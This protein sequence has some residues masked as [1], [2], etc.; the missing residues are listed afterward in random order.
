M[1]LFLY[2][3]A[4]LLNIFAC[5]P[6]GGNFVTGLLVHQ[7]ALRATGVSALSV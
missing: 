5:R 6:D 4:T 2:E 3:T 1:R 7:N